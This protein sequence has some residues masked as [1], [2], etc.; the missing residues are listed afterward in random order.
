MGVLTDVVTVLHGG[1]GHVNTKAVG[2]P[3]GLCQTQKQTQG[4]S[5][6]SPLPGPR[7][8]QEIYFL[9]FGPWDKRTAGNMTSL[10]LAPNMNLQYL[11]SLGNFC[12]ICFDLR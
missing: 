2:C 9:Q 11:L 5:E 8:L 1:Q 6:L 10:G 4:R 7:T 12:K 3:W